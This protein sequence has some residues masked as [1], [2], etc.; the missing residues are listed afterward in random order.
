MTYAELV[1][2]YWKINSVH[3]TKT[4]DSCLYMYLLFC[5]EVTCSGTIETSFSKISTVTLIDRRMISDAFDRLILKGFVTCFFH[6]NK[7]LIITIKQFVPSNTEILLYKNAQPIEQNC[8]TDNL[9][10]QNI[11]SIVHNCTTESEVTNTVEHNRTTTIDVSY[12]NLYNTPL[13]LS[14]NVQPVVL[15]RT[16]NPSISSSNINNNNSTNTNAKTQTQKLEVTTEI[17][18]RA[19]E[20]N[21]ELFVTDISKQFT[22]G[23]CPLAQIL[24]ENFINRNKTRTYLELA[25]VEIHF[26]N[27]FNLIST[28]KLKGIYEL[29]KSRKWLEIIEDLQIASIDTTSLKGASIKKIEGNEITIQVQ[30]EKQIDFIESDEVIHIFKKSFKQKFTRYAKIKYTNAPTK[31]SAKA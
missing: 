20:I 15:N 3:P 21:N 28:E 6:K 23:S 26:M 27:A 8:T 18:H 9:L 30:Q 4:Q 17:L 1:F 5:A 22:N 12:T 7:G 14:K 29:G 19:Q 16:T 10:N 31:A 11:E 24:I 25:D 2:Q 13:E